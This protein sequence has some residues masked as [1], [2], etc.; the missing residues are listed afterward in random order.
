MARRPYFVRLYAAAHKMLPRSFRRTFGG[1]MTQVFEDLHREARREAGWPGALRHLAAEFKDFSW[2]AWQELCEQR[3]LTRRYAFVAGSSRPSQGDCFKMSLHLTLVDLRITMRRLLRAPGFALLALLVLSLGLGSTVYMYN[4]TS[5][6]SMKGL[7]FEHGERIMGLSATHQRYAGQRYNLALHDYVEFL[8]Q[9][10]SFE[11]L[12]AYKRRAVNV[13]GD[14]SR[15]ERVRAATTTASLFELVGVEALHGRTFAPADEAPGAQRVAVLGYTLWKNRYGGDPNVVGS[16]IR[17]DG[18]PATVVGVMPDG[19]EFPLRERLWQPLTFDPAQTPRRDSPRAGVVGRL[20]AGVSLAEASSEM[21]TISRRLEDAYP[22]TNEG[23]GVE[24]VAYTLMF[25]TDGAIAITYVMLGAVLFVLL[26][27]CANVSHLLLVRA[28]EKGPELAIRSALGASRGRLVVQ[29]LFESLLVSLTAAV[30]GC[31]LAAW[32]LARS[33]EIIRTFG[34]FQPFWWRFELGAE[35]VA[36]ALA[37]ALFSALFSGLLPALRATR[38]D[39]VSDLDAAARGSTSLRLGRLS[40]VLVIG[41]I[42][43]SCVLL[44]AAGLAIR[45]TVNALGRDLGAEVEGFLQARIGLTGTAYDDEETRRR[46]YDELQTRLETAP[47][48]RAATFGSGLPGFVS[49]SSRYYTPSGVELGE[50]EPKP[51]ALYHCVALDYFETFQIPLVAGR[52]FD[53]R[54]HARASPVIIV[55]RRLAEKFWNDAEAI[56]QRIRLGE[57][58]HEVVGVVGEVV[59]IPEAPL[60]AIYVPLDQDPGT[61]VYVALATGADPMLAAPILR[62]ALAAL[63]SDLAAFDVK[64]LPERVAEEYNDL[65]FVGRLFVLFGLMALAMASAGLYGVVAFSVARRTREI[66]VR[67]A[68]GATSS[69]LLRLI[70]RRGLWE[71]AAGLGIGLAMAFPVTR[72]MT[73]I[74]VDVEPTDPASILAAVLALSG[75]VAL[76]C[77]VPA[78][79]AVAIEPVEALRNE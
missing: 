20:S 40:H 41:E 55:S 49:V 1:D 77:F 34:D 2:L 39:T 42:A 8:G 37:A 38:S 70:A 19:F 79:R 14:T 57:E 61:Q 9:Q 31:G 52:P 50:D 33:N 13:S 4:M 47:G 71:L 27:A 28:Q 30:L 64:P 36:L 26:I 45:S 46:F 11:H 10:R 54:D 62:D 15:P 17:L 67:R 51:R 58:W 16:T 73:E 53:R 23:I 24:V 22:E 5:A 75:A 6:V 76:A 66:G 44:I 12:A 69:S 68:L 59:N 29:M 3:L 18:E 78:S 25:L 65:A 35:S 72:L 56:G 7:P 21:S 43:L 63:D 74:L 32:G 48:M 60:E